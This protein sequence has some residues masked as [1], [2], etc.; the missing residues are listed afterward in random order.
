MISALIDVVLLLAVVACVWHNRVTTKK[1]RA[2]REAL[3]ELGPAIESFSQ[4]VDHSRMSITDMRMTAE[5]VAKQINEQA[6]DARSKL[7]LLSTSAYTPK[8]KIPTSGKENLISQ[9]F[10]HARGRN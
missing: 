3:V 8:V 6:R 1:L 10:T 2:L 9:F 4:A 5:D 7:D